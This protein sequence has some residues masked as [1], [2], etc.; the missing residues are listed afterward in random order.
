MHSLRKLAFVPALMVLMG[1]G[2]GALRPLT[3]KVPCYQ[4][5]LGNGVCDD[6]NPFVDCYTNDAGLCI[7]S[8]ARWPYCPI[9]F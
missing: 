3:G 9:I 1:A 5:N 6:Y 8:K 4:C 7:Y 2:Y